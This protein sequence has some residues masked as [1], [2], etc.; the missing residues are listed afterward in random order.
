MMGIV[1]AFGIRFGNR[2]LFDR[3]VSQDYL[4][5][6][7]DEAVSERIVSMI[8]QRSFI[9]TTLLFILRADSYIGIDT[10]RLLRYIAVQSARKKL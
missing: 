8:M 2:M 5:M 3:E 9:R 4:Y 7:Y 6:P 1:L 10:G